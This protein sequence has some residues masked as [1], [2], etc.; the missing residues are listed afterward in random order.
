MIATGKMN[1]YFE[2]EKHNLPQ[3]MLKSLR[4]IAGITSKVT[5]VNHSEDGTT[6]LLVQLASG[7]SVETVVMKYERNRIRYSACLSSQVGCKMNCTFCA[8]GTMGFKQQLT[9]YEILEQLFHAKQIQNVTNVIMMG[10]G[11]PFD[12]YNALILSVR[13]MI[14]PKLFGLGPSHVTVSTVGVVPKLKQ[15]SIDCPGVKLALSLHASNQK[16]RLEL[17]PMAKMYPLDELMEAVDLYLTQNDK[18]MIEYIM[19]ENINSSSKDAEELSKLLESRNV[20]VNLI[21]Y[22]PT[23]TKIVY[24]VPSNETI[25][26]FWR[27][28]KK[29]NIRAT[30]RRTMGQDI[31]GACGQLVVDMEDMFS[32]K[33]FNMEIIIFCVFLRFLYKLF[34]WILN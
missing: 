32:K 20:I 26:N 2:A 17:V 30:V 27:I 15:F 19:I 8:T 21:P 31:K 28:L 9:A 10:M 1:Q 33:K 14:N 7:R 24:K 12:N 18:I 3:K 29:N 25:Q 13:E 6:K 22:N 23:K 11:E 16:T 34:G 5:S 4:N